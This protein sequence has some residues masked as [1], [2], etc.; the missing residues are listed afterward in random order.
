MAKVIQLRIKAEELRID[1][2]SGIRKEELETEIQKKQQAIF[3]EG[4]LQKPVR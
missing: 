2:S 3:A 4:I 1:N